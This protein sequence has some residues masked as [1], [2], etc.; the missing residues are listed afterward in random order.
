M[1]TVSVVIPTY[2]RAKFLANAI[3]SVLT[4]SFQDFE[5]IIVDD[6]STDGTCDVAQKFNS[7]ICYVRQENHGRSHA[8]NQGI[9]YSTGRYIHFLDS[10]DILLPEALESL[11]THLDSHPDVGVVYGDGMRVDSQQRSSRRISASRPSIIGRTWLE[12][13]TICN[14]IDAIHSAMVRRHWLDRIGHP[15]FDE[16]LAAAEDLD[17]W[18]RLAEIGCQYQ[19]I[20]ALVCEYHIHGSNT[21][22]PASPGIQRAFD[23]LMR[24]RQ[25]VFSSDFFLRLPENVQYLFLYDWIISRK[26]SQEIQSEVFNSTRFR[27]LSTP[28][29]SQLL[30]YA[31]MGNLVDGR[32]NVGQSQLRAAARLCPH[33]PKYV[34]ARWLAELCSPTLRSTVLARRS[35][36]TLW[37]QLA[38]KTHVD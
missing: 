11:A 20:D 18:T 14:V 9:L 17:L 8:R 28:V 34:L 24:Q 23:S 13:F 15:Y 4:Q 6:G 37:N 19:S 36:G 31:G 21:Y 2:N 38:S 30:Y 27:E 3:Q 26:L 22:S 12:A 10:D 5:L 33:R 16:S 29:R 1:P 32:G 25:K 7:S 35:A